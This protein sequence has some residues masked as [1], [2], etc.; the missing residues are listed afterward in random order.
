MLGE[1]RR[2]TSLQSMEAERDRREQWRV[3][4]RV[5]HYTGEYTL[6]NKFDR[7]HAHHTGRRRRSIRG[8]TTR[9]LTTGI[10]SAVTGS[11]RTQSLGVNSRESRGRHTWSGVRGC[12]NP[13]VKV[14][15]P[16]Q[17]PFLPFTVN[18]FLVFLDRRKSRDRARRACCHFDYQPPRVICS[19]IPR[20]SC[21]Y[22]RS[23]LF[24]TV[25]TDFLLS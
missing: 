12:S 22:E 5:R 7:A 20:S 18:L 25:V 23:R 9:S 1:F 13:V 15:V 8:S 16:C 24:M 6:V 3:V 19:I 2:R 21:F 14:C 4:Y 17:R 11:S 10:M